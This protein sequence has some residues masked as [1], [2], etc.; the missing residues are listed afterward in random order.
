MGCLFYMLIMDSLAPDPWAKS[1]R[2]VVLVVDYAFRVVSAKALYC[3]APES[4]C[5]AVLLFFF[6]FF[7]GKSESRLIFWKIFGNPMG[8]DISKKG[9]QVLN[10]NSFRRVPY[11]T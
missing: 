5:N 10:P 8:P 1:S 3:M 4:T 6:L 11:T 7:K 2:M 9:D